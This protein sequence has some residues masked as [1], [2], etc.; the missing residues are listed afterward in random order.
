MGGVLLSCSQQLLIDRL[1]A[2]HALQFAVFEAK[3]LLFGEADLV[4]QRRCLRLVLHDIQL[5]ARLRNFGL[6]IFQVAL[7]AAALGLFLMLA[8][9]QTT[10]CLSVRFQFVFDGADAARGRLQRGAQL[11]DLYIELLQANQVFERGIH[12]VAW[13]LNHFG[14]SDMDRSASIVETLLYTRLVNPAANIY[15]G[16]RSLLFVSSLSLR[17]L[18]LPLLAVS[19]ASSLPA[20]P[21]QAPL[22]V[23]AIFTDPG[24]TADAPKGIAWA[25]DGTMLTYLNS[26]GDLVAVDG[27]TA[28]TRVLIPKQKMGGT[29]ANSA[30]EQD[31]DHRSRYGEASYLWAPDSKHVLFDTNGALFLYSLTQGVAVAVAETG[32]GSGD[33]PKFAPDGSALSYVRDHDLYLRRLPYSQPAMRLTTVHDDAT[34]NGQVDWLYL[35]ELDV[36]S[37]Y[38]WSPDS[39]SIAYLQMNEGA[40]PQY[41]I[42]DWIPT[43]A[44]VEMQRYPQ[45]GD[46]NPSV[47]VGVVNTGSG[48]NTWMKVPL[49]AGNDYIPRFGWVN[50]RTLWIE[51]LT[52]DH[53]HRRLYF[54]DAANGNTRLVLE[55]NDAKFFDEAYDLTIDGPH[56]LWTSWRDGHTQIYLYSF[57]EANPMGGEAKLV[58]QLTSGNGEVSAI[59]SLDAKA[60]TVYYLS[61]EEDPREQQLWSV[62]L[63]GTG[64]RQVT[65]TPGVHKPEFSPNAQ[66]FV[67]NYSNITTPP[68]LS[69]CHPGE[70]DACRS[71]WHTKIDPQYTLMSPQELKLKASDGTTLYASLMLPPGKQK[72]G[73]VPL[74]NN[75]YGGPHAQTVQNAWGGRTTLF[76]Q[77]LAEHGFAVLHVD[78]RGMGGRGRDFAQAAYHN[79]GPVQLED[80]LGAM[81][82]VLE[83]FPELDAKRQGWWGW[84]W[85]GTF[86]LYAM[87]HSDRFKAGVCVAPVTDWHNY[88]STYTERYMSLPREN[89]DQYRDF[90]VVTNADKLSGRLL[91]VHG[92]GDDNVHMENTIQFIQKLID[93]EL[94]YDLQLYPR[95]TH[96]IAGPVARTHLYTRILAQF[97]AYL[98]E[99]SE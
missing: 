80:Q 70:E 15:P 71:F 37:N 90:S 78:N 48:H 81:D 9:L 66:R 34:L 10:D 57:D 74:I 91:L 21:K 29:T 60:S 25:P 46:P 5:L 24:L 82:Q 12:H 73:S 72:K 7:G 83:Q 63:D 40:V 94:P 2:H 39:K 51:T 42:T 53:K 43:H 76:D 32:S 31:K 47:R 62:K 86:T 52:R 44:T 30:S 67:D 11:P 79:F 38:F 13:S 87:T 55:E 64:K 8:L 20:A 17:I 89:A 41:P 93:A 35:E 18:A 36:R 84:S 33:D 4:L 26:A 75:P 65:H 54:A 96:S 49:D 27:T 98:A 92:T 69:I 16:C 99:K 22:T 56:I 3:D 58:R 61:N 19:L 50:H 23:S 85:G 88:D 45:P 77:I 97:E 14:A 59:K 68:A 6:V 1:G 95:K 28:Q